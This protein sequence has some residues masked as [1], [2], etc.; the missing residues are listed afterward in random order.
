M[1]GVMHRL[2]H[3]YSTN[4]ILS[5]PFPFPSCL[6]VWLVSSAN[7]K[8]TRPSLLWRIYSRKSQPAAN[9]QECGDTRLLAAKL[10]TEEWPTWK[11]EGIPPYAPSNIVMQ[12]RQPGFWAKEEWPE[13][14]WIFSVRSTGNRVGVLCMSCMARNPQWSP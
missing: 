7:E 12:Y 10:Y 6:L 14:R 4:T 13:T 3:R 9:R 5:Q 2:F 1:P 11:H 8:Q